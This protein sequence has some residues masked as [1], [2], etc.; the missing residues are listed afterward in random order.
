MDVL[1]FYSAISTIFGYY[2]QYNGASYG[3]MTV[4]DICDSISTG[5][6][7]DNFHALAKLLQRMYYSLEYDCIEFSNKEY[8]DFAS[9]TS[10]D[11]PAVAHGSRIWN[12]QLCSE[13]ASFQTTNSKNQPFFGL[14]TDLFVAQ[15]QCAFGE[16]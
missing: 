13:V 9:K 7:H 16:K 2:T 8:C 12:W 3:V 15:C 1:N 4:K 10:W 14:T 11:D 5:G 6:Q